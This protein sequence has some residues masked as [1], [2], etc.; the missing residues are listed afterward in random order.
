[1]ASQKLP[2]GGGRD[3]GLT[4]DSLFDRGLSNPESMLLSELL[5]FRLLRGSS[6]AALNVQGLWLM[7]TANS[8][9]ERREEREKE[10]E[11]VFEWETRLW[12]LFVVGWQHGQISY[13]SQTDKLYIVCN[14]M[15]ATWSERYSYRCKSNSCSTLMAKE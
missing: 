13:T 9:G 7:E 10:R 15:G 4:T 11:R 8:E 6:M 14:T 1:M 2:G 5:L 12:E 3:R